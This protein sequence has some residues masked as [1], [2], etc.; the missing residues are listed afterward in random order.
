MSGMKPSKRSVAGR[1]QGTAGDPCDIRIHIDLMG[2]RS[3]VAQKLRAGDLL[4]VEL[5][6]DGPLRSVVCQTAEGDR[7]G[8][9]SAF[10]GLA[11]F[12]RCIEQGVRYSALVER[13]SGHSCSVFV[14]RSG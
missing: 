13:S 10:P 5:I 6:V 2:V 3:E 11:Q 12:I 14:A 1:R 7:V 8:A 9:L 4:K